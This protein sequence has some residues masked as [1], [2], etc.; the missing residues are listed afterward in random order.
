MAWPCGC[1]IGVEDESFGI[2]DEGLDEA[3]LSLLLTIRS[4]EDENLNAVSPF[5]VEGEETVTSGASGFSRKSV[6]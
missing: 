5:E 4:G 2:E 6:E 1:G 3:L